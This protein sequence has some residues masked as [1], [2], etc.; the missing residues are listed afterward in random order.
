MVPWSGGIPVQKSWLKQPAPRHTASHQPF[1][2]AFPG[3]HQPARRPP[4]V[5]AGFQA[6]PY[7]RY[8]G[9]V[10]MYNKWRGFGFIGVDPGLIPTDRIFVHWKS[11]CSDDRFPFLVS[12]MQVEFGVVVTN[13]WSRGVTL[14]VKDVTLPG[15]GQIAMQD[16]LDA[17]EKTFLGGQHLRYTGTLRQYNPRLGYGV[18]IMDPGYDIDAS[19]PAELRVEREEVNA[20]GQQAVYMEN[21]AVEFGIWREASGRF[22]VYNM[23]MPG[24]HPLTRDALENRISIGGSTFPGTVAIW[25]WKAGWGFIRI[26]PG[27]ALPAS[28]ERKLAQQAQ[29]ARARGRTITEER[30]LYFRRAD[31]T[32]GLNVMSGLRVA[33]AV[34]VDDK[35]AGAY[36][37][38]AQDL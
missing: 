2:Q 36:D 30:M 19:V 37:V 21:L 11:L 27:Y 13:D 28:V 4:A 14:R 31:C 25:N 9:T 17:Q 1:Q 35:G 32:L 5:P 8:S 7:A 15:G 34:Y 24:G 3:Y 16:E 29:E 18:V 12:G 6:D 23:T 38:T 20:G 22:K 10:S 33:F 26:D